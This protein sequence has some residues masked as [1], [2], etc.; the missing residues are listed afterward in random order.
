MASLVILKKNCHR[1]ISTNGYFKITR[2][3][4]FY[5]NGTLTLKREVEQEKHF[6]QINIFKIIYELTFLFDRYI[7]HD[8]F[9]LFL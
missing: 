2:S 1:N 8:T 4:S 7:I 9:P 5:S 6:K 3:I